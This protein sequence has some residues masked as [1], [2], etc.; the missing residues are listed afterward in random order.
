MTGGGGHPPRHPRAAPARRLLGLGEAAAYLG[1]PPDAV[2]ALVDARFLQPVDDQPGEPRLALTELRAFM[3]WNVGEGDGEV[4]DLEAEVPA[5]EAL[6]EALR[7]RTSDLAERALE[8]Y[9]HVFPEAQGWSPEDQARFVHRAERRLQAIVALSTPGAGAEGLAGELHLAVA[10]E[11]AL[12]PQLLVE[13]RVSRDLLIQ[14]AVEAVE[15]RGRQWGLAL[16]LL[17]ARV[18]AAADRLTD[19]VAQQHWS[20]L[21]AGHKEARARY[22]HMVEHWP[23]GVYEMDF[24]GRIR[25]ANPQL[26]LI[27]GRRRSQELE[28]A[29]ISD[30]MEPVSGPSTAVLLHPSGGP[31]GLELTVSRPDGVRRVLQVRSLP[32][33]R[34]DQPVGWLGVVRDVTAA[35]DL[36]A[37]R[38]R[39]LDSLLGDLR[40]ALVG[41]AELGAGLEAEA[42]RLS[43]ER[44]RSVGTSILGHLEPLAALT[45]EVARVS[46]MPVEAPVLAARPVELGEVVRTAV[47]ASEARAEQLDVQVPA[48][49]RVL[50]DP[51]GLVG[52]VGDLVSD[53]ARHGQAPVR[54]EVEGVASGELQLAMTAPD[55]SAGARW[56]EEGAGRARALV[57]AMGGRVWYDAAEGG[58]RY[59]LAVPVPNRRRGDE[60]IRL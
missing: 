42:G 35:R 22:Q 48:G 12:L 36:Q 34:D 28:G 9:A 52:A 43:G 60:V 5:P 54:V 16:S 25:Y 50:A 19:S 46:R 7:G 31:H 14:A 26:G 45:D 58:G 51:E 1:L 21:V 18:V 39:L 13:P 29:L 38:E 11:E 37:Q 10:G 24:E 4:I 20:A 15:D 57:E 32:M 44:V 30:V 41:L 33:L 55:P 23:D 59:R 56:D 8:T 47:V 17:L 3:V 53:A 40:L 2:Q 49:L 27:L 6:L